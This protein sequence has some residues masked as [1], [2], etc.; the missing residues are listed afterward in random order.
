LPELH[1]LVYPAKPV[2]KPIAASNEEFERL[3]YIWEFCNNFDEF[4]NT[5]KFRIEDL[6]LALR[7]GSHPEATDDDECGTQL[8]VDNF[9]EEQEAA[10]AA[11]DCSWTEQMTDKQLS[12][13]GFNMVNVLHL[14]LLGCFMQDLFQDGGQANEPNSKAHQPSFPMGESSWAI[15]AAIN[16]SIV[17]K[18]K[19]Q[20]WPEIVRLLLVMRH[21]VEDF[22]DYEEAMAVVLEKL[23][24]M[25]PAAFCSAFTYSEKLTLLTV[26][27]DAVHDLNHFRTFL[28]SR[29]DTKTQFNKEK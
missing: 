21:E 28:N 13:L 4:L 26:L 8:A 16:K 15:L 17:E 1:G 25:E 2:A 24:G 5:P 6:R 29:Q 9:R 12:E 11:Y 14:A 22:G 27:I 3:L 20:I 23:V 18:E 7:W 19:E 10:I